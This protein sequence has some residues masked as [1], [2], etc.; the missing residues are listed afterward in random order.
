MGQ[1][2]SQ[3]L[4]SRLDVIAT[5]ERGE[6][7]DD[8]YMGYS[9]T[10]GDFTGDGQG[11]TAVGMPRGSQLLGKVLLYTWNMTNLYNLTG[12][13][14]GAYFGYSLCV[15]DV[16]GDQLDDVVVGA[17]MYTDLS[18]NEGKYDTGRIYIFYQGKQNKF[19]RFDVRDGTNSKCRFGLALT[20]LGD[21][22]K[23][24]FAD[25]A[26]GAP[27]DGPNERG[28]VYIFHGSAS[29]AMEKHSQIIFAEDIQATLSTFGFSLSGGVDLDENEYPDIVV[30]AYESDT[31]VI[32]NFD[33]QFVLDSKKPK[34]P[35]LF[36]LAHEGKHIMNFT[37]R[38]TIRDKLTP[39]EVELRYSLKSNTQSQLSDTSRRR[40]SRSLAPILDLD[41]EQIARDSISIQTNCGIN[42]ICIPDLYLLAKPSECFNPSSI[43]ALLGE[44]LIYLLFFLFYLMTL[45][46]V[47]TELSRLEVRSGN[48]AATHSTRWLCRLFISSPRLCNSK[49]SEKGRI[50]EE[51]YPR[52]RLG[53][54]KDHI[55]KTFFC[56]FGWDTNP[57]IPI[58]GKPV[59]GQSDF[60]DNTT[61]DAG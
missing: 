52:L 41:Q 43:V 31:A 58:T 17:P 59:S 10:V 26:V 60:L 23:D 33:V 39:L 5:K 18:N 9:V 1:M 36:F 32:Y 28:A 47:L 61:I 11:G 24:G 19:Q 55:R 42:N 3:N 37:Y 53:R 56:T 30:G 6:Q 40:V 7:D 20:S 14:L 49:L 22:N 51:A 48:T 4:G 29:G 44:V 13:Q 54:V 38:P 34:S 15:V 50:L 46:T 45:I 21:I 16:D 35:R 12:E 25:F 57:Y 8:S 27:Y 2:Y